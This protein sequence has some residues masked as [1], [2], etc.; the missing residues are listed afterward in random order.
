MEFYEGKEE[1]V[2]FAYCNH[3][4]PGRDFNNSWPKLCALSF[5]I[6]IVLEVSFKYG[7]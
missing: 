2:A 1:M 5:Y 4:G 3:A 6:R 7:C